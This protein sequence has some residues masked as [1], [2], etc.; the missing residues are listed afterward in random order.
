VERRF[1]R[2]VHLLDDGFQHLRLARD[3]DVLCVTMEDL[4]DRPLPAGQLREFPGAIS[5]AHVVLWNGGEPLPED[6]ARRPGCATFMVKRHV[7]GFFDLEGRPQ[8]APARPYLLA[9]IARPERFASDVGARVGEIA[10]CAFFRDHHPFT[11]EEVR[12]IEAEASSL[13][14]DALVTT[15][16]DAVRLPSAA[17]SLPLLVLRISAAVID[18]E[19]LKGRLVAVAAGIS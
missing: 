2:R 18:E 1:G 5:R 17:L 16:K 4:D 10:G 12:S 7:E 19:S 15:A 14:A 11:E 3:L 8:A 6:L 13:G 9:G